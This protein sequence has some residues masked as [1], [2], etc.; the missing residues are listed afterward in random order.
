MFVKIEE[1]SIEVGLVSLFMIVKFLFDPINTFDNVSSFSRHLD[2][3]SR[4]SIM[5]VEM[6]RVIFVLFIIKTSIDL[7]ES[8]R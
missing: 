8:R 1:G 3:L 5:G 4:A 2:H 6:V 7:S